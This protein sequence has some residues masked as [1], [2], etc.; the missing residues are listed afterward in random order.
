MS[1][2]KILLLEPNYKNKYPPMGLMKIASYYRCRGD[3]VRFYKGDLKL[4]AAQLLFED[5]FG[6]IDIGNS[7]IDKV[8]YNYIVKR[9]SSELVSYIKTG[10]KSFL[11]PI[12]DFSEIS[13]DV[14]ECTINDLLDVLSVYNKRN[15]TE[16]F[17]KFDRVCVTT[18]FTFYWKQ[19]IATIEFAKKVCKKVKGVSVGGIAASLVPDYIEKE[20]GI[21]PYVGLLDVPFA[22]DNDKKGDVI[23]DELP[24]DYSILDEIDYRY[25]TENAYFGYMTR[26]CTNRC[27]FCAVPKLEPDYCNFIGIKEKIEKIDECFGAKRDLLLMDNNVFASDCFDK[28][29]DEIKDCGFEKGATYIPAN[30]YDIAY[31]NLINGFNLGVWARKRVFNDRAYYRKLIQIYD[32]I[33]ERLDG[34]E[35]GDFYSKREELGLL[36]FETATKEAVETIHQFAK[37]LYDKHFKQNS[38]VRFIDFNQGLDGRLV[39]DKKMKKISETAIR[40]LRIAFDHWSMKKSYEKAVKT[41]IKYKI[42]N[43]S[44]YLLYNFN[45]HPDELYE[46][47][48]MNIELCDLGVTIYSFP[49]KYHPID[50]PDYFRNRDYIGKP[51]W[52]RKFIRAIQAVLNSTHGKIGRGK[53][54]FEAAFGKDID[55]FH[56]ILWMPEALIIQRYKYDIVKRREYYGDKPTPY[57]DVDERTSNITIE[58]WKKF[59]ALTEKQRKKAEQIIIEHR[60]TDDDIDVS[61]KKVKEVLQF[62]QI[63][64]DDTKKTEEKSE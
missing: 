20:T 31:R 35:K 36:Y 38:R 14:E 41:A 47:M 44:N 49:M 40:P 15:K 19:N 23:I 17:P 29:I 4:F 42:N 52:N 26:G 32:E 7:P 59:N 51:H 16:D 55:E 58:W 11:K 43:L 24:L 22:Y 5:Y 27:S 28:I 46:R 63:K 57:D 39:T 30:E 54:F 64:R 18:L 53:T 13:A 60:F 8:I 3:N 9:G 6:S 37:L 2:R 12:A 62:Y 45:D 61:D 48:R 50:D 1:K 25:P 33:S 56:K 21:K 34:K 10:N